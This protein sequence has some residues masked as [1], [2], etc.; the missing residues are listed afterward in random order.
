M[1][2]FEKKIKDSKEVIEPSKKNNAGEIY[3]ITKTNIKTRRSIKDLFTFRLVIKYAVFLLF[4]ALVFTSGIFVSNALRDK[5]K[6]PYRTDENGNIIVEKVDNK[7]NDKPLTFGSFETEDELISYLSNNQVNVQTGSNGGWFTMD[8]EKATSASI[9]NATASVKEFNVS[10]TTN[11]QVENVDEADIVKVHGNNIFYLPYG[12]INYYNNDV[13]KVY[14]FTEVN[15][16]LK[17]AKTIEYTKKIE[18]LKKY[19]ETY[20]EVKVTNKRPLDLYVTDKYLI[21]HIGYEEYTGLQEEGKSGIRGNYDYLYRNSF[22]VYNIDTLDYVTTIET[23]GSNVSTRLIGNTLYVINNYYDYYRS[24]YRKY[25]M[26]YILIDGSYLGISLNSIYYCGENEINA[27]SY[28]SIYKITLDEEIKVEDI[29]IITPTVNNIYSTDKNIYL[30]RSYGTGYE[31][32]SEY[33]LEYSK[34]RVVVVNIEDGLSLSG[35]FDVKGQIR[36]KYWIDEKDDCIRVVTTGNQYKR[37]Y[38]DNKYLFKSESN[39]F[40]QLTIFKNT[41][42]GF[43]QVGV[44]DDGLGKPG[45]TIRSARFNGDVVTVVTFKNTDPLY[46]IDISDPN[47]PV[48]TS[49]L[50]ITG[51]SVYQHPYKDNYVIGFGYETNESGS[52]IG[53]KITLFDV[54]DKNNIKEVGKPYVIKREAGKSGFH[55]A[56][57]FFSDPKALLINLDRDMFGFRMRLYNYSN[58]NSRYYTIKYFVFKINLESETPFEIILNKKSD[59]CDYYESLSYFDRMVFIGKNYYLLSAKKVDIYQY[60]DGKLNSNGVIDLE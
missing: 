2:D 24:N 40:N 37:Y 23:A 41:S 25:Y 3:E 52:T 56:P 27:K 53:Y 55:S 48:I 26:P 15:G 28:V 35:S 31:E 49:S 12:G 9:Q 4:I 51:Y 14:M 13:N 6:V 39:N 8:E 58:T 10:Y 1:E 21:V 18:E 47:N 42:D 50:E 57:D 38:F 5:N 19:D 30:I 17:L 46:Y 44:I 43:I 22:E 60:N 45:E 20:S 32:T 16:E 11:T 29:H 34:S 54:S 36:D 59:Q 33:T 7:N